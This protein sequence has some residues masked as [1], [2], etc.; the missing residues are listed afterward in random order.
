MTIRVLIVDDEPLV[1]SGLRSILGAEPDIEIV[2]EAG[3]GAEAVTACR[4]L[5]PD[6][7]CMDVRMPRVDGIRATEL[8]LRL[9][10]P[11][12]VLVITTFSSDEYV[13]DALRA[14]ASGFVLKRADAD[15][16]IA[17]VRTV[18]AGDNLLYPATV[19]DL[20]LRSTASQ[21][22]TG[23]PLTAREQDVL[24]LMAQGLSNP[25]IAERL[26]L[27]VETVRTHVAS[28]LRKLDARD[29]THAVVLAYTQGLVRLPR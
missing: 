28:I 2:G 1:R 15:E 20:A 23:T 6:L 26:V 5:Q 13:F 27:G 24:A 17:A 22:Y 3:D 7:V 11:P 16:L 19:R 18:L 10:T 29:R 21:T 4:R 9:P 25:A 12:R 14:G 8:V